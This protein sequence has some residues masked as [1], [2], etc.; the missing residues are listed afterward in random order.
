[1]TGRKRKH[2]AEEDE[3]TGLCL[4]GCR[5]RD[6]R[7]VKTLN[8]DSWTIYRPRDWREESLIHNIISRDNTG[9]GGR[10]GG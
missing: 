1:M 2:W 3:N 9:E 5:A 10:N 7:E 8:C 6:W 4:V